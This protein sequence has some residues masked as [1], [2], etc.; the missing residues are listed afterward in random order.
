MER[1][2]GVS[3]TRLH[4]RPDLVEVHLDLLQ[5]HQVPEEDVVGRE[6]LGRQQEPQRP[7]NLR[8]HHRSVTKNLF[9]ARK[10]LAFAPFHRLGR[11]L[12]RLLFIAA[13][14]KKEGEGREGRGEGNALKSRERD[15]QAL[16]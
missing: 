4:P 16:K 1:E 8:R 9:Q 5:T 11:S 10:P 14:V 15:S 3:M 7:R 6:Y 13:E 2:G 12:I